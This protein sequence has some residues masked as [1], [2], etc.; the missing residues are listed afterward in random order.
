MVVLCR[1]PS[2]DGVRGMDKLPFLRLDRSVGV[3]DLSTA[4][5]H[6]SSVR[7]SRQ[8]RVSIASLIRFEGHWLRAWKEHH[9]GM[10][11]LN[12]R[13]KTDRMLREVTPA[14]A[15]DFCARQKIAL[16]AALVATLEEPTPRRLEVMPDTYPDTGNSPRVV[17]PEGGERTRPE[18]ALGRADIGSVSLIDRTL[19]KDV[20]AFVDDAE[21]WFRT[22]NPAFEGRPPIELLGTDDE[23]RLRNRIAG[24]KLGMFS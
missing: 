7:R 11:G 24:D 21:R 18:T 1:V 17:A 9:P 3:L 12:P 20:G 10:L 15:A 2:V 13:L 5:F 4:V 22:P 14:A 23:P 16:P 6:D 19:L 8:S